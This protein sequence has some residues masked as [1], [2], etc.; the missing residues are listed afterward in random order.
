MG[1]AVVTNLTSHDFTLVRKLAIARAEHGN[2]PRDLELAAAILC[3]FG[4]RGQLQ[5]EQLLG[6]NG[7]K[8]GASSRIDQKGGDEQMAELVCAWC[9][10]YCRVECV[11]YDDEGPAGPEAARWFPVLNTAASRR[12]SRPSA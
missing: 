1:A 10:V 11:Q 8:I 2:R 7:A 6:L 4:K 12:R 9:D 3:G 5:P